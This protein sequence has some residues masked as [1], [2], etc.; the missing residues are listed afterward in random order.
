MR[1]VPLLALL[2]PTTTQHNWVAQNVTD[3]KLVMALG[4]HGPLLPRVVMEA[5]RTAE[6]FHRDD[7]GLVPGRDWQDVPLER[8]RVTVYEIERRHRDVELPGLQGADKMLRTPVPAE[9]NEA[10]LSATPRL[11]EPGQS[12]VGPEKPL[13]IVVP[14][15]V[16][17]DGVNARRTEATEASSD[18][19][20]GALLALLRRL[21]HD[22]QPSA[23]LLEQR[24]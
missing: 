14:D 11:L 3:R 21:R 15:V 9:S 13:Q 19:I 17:Q 24:G 18:R 2:H 6:R 10:D 12:P 16:E 5:D 4:Q 8:I 22:E 7:A 1:A 23:L 20:H